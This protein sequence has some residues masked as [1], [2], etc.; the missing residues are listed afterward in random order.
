MGFS[1]SLSGQVGSQLNSAFGAQATSAIGGLS[2]GGFN[3]GGFLNSMMRT[4]PDVPYN[5]KLQI[6]GIREVHFKE[7]SGLKCT[8]D[9]EVLRQGGDNIHEYYL[10]KGMKF[11]PLKV[12]RGY[13]GGAT[14]FYAWMRQMHD[15]KAIKRKNIGLFVLND[16]MA[17]VATFNIYNAIPV[18]FTGPTFDSVMKGSIAFEEIE[19]RYEYFEIEV[20]SFV[21]K[22]ISGAVGAGISMA[23]SAV[24]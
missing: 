9:V 12:K 14:E 7:V 1:A 22:A 8:T 13:F 2:I 19:I 23:A 15:T 3:I 18:A 11:D 20:P 4:D 10:L 21:E 17:E 6:D 16:K 24:F 5:F